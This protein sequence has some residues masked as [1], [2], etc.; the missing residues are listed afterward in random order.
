MTAPTESPDAPNVLLVDD[1]E[2]VRT[3]VSRF[4]SKSGYQVTSAGS[5][6]EAV[7]ILSEDLF[8]VALVD[9]QMPGMSGM[10]LVEAA[11]DRAPN[12]AIVILTGVNDAK[13]AAVCIQRGAVDYLVKPV[14]PEVLTRSIDRARKRR[15]EA[16]KTR[17][18]VVTH[19]LEAQQLAAELELE[20]EKQQLMSLATLDALIHAQ[21]AKDPYQIGHSARV[22][23]LAASIAVEMGMSDDEIEVVRVAARLHDLGNIGIREAVLTKKGSLTD[24][25]YRHVKEHVYIGHQI[26]S[27]MTALGPIASFVRSHHE[28][29]DGSGYPDGLQGE[30]IPLGG[31]I[32]C[33]AEIFDAVSTARPYQKQLKDAAALSRLGELVGRVL[34]PKVFDALSAAI[35]RHRNL[36]FIV[37]RPRLRPPVS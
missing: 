26:L 6:E 20:K 3:S 31:R 37:D 35:Q 2:Q 10:D 24:D 36:T 13:T 27:P 17:E 21:E 29:W 28:H 32:L 18:R 9:L 8:E 11:L 14:A 1:D 22:A 19:Q 16:I 5:G 30:G 12:L 4:L 33:A 15:S 25:E 7:Q 23:D 34:D